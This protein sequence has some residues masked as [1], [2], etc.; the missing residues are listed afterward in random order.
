MTIPESSTTQLL[1]LSKDTKMFLKRIALKKEEESGVPV[2]VCKL[3]RDAIDFTYG[4]DYDR[5]K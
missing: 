4:R 1:I 5:N 2:S 3:V